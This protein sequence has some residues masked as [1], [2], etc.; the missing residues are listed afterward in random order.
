MSA[1]IKFRA[2][3]PVRK[4]LLYSHDTYGLGHIRRNLAIAE[5]LLARNPSLQIV[6]VSGSVV[7][8]RFELPR[9][10]SL[11]NLPPVVKAGPESYR[12]LDPRLSLGLVRRA[13]TAVIADVTRRLKPDLLLVDHAPAGM[14]G[15]LL[16][17]FEMLS[18]ERARTRI[19]LGLRDVL[20]EPEAV[21]DTWSRQGIYK[22]LDEVYDEIYV[23]GQRD[24]FDVGSAYGMPPSVS[25]RLQYTGYLD[26]SRSAP[27]DLTRIDRPFLLATAGGGG[28]GAEVLS[29]ALEAGG[30]LG[31]GTL[32]VTGP[33][34]DAPQ[35]AALDARAAST[36]R[37]R[38]VTFDP[39]LGSL[40]RA[41]SV[42][43]TMGGY[44]S[45]CE[46]VAAGTPTIVVPRTWPR[47]E[48]LVRA[49]L[50]A[51][52]GLVDVVAQ[53]PGLAERLAPVI[54]DR[55]RDPLRRH[56]GIDLDGLDRLTTGLL[57]HDPV[58]DMVAVREELAA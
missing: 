55:L 19:V 22:L 24:M 27:S 3:R 37:A 39:A 40:M 53:G 15:E 41:A 20:D 11:V 1:L 44:N 33:L 14:G 58:S 23:Y 31:L 34:I 26:R 9:G 50:F 47:R 48:Q 30:R 57:R 16:K 38:V 28:D 45:M 51:E 21:V 42:V 36:P 4:V 6:L 18:R 52:R 43:V 25:R 2:E 17:V 35:R 29:A 12:P 54:R 13:R 7:G 5:H 8:H 46:A 10:L 32:V 49:E 56:A